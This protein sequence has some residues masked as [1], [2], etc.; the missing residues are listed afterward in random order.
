MQSYTNWFFYISIACAFLTWSEWRGRLS[1]RSPWSTGSRSRELTLVEWSFIP[2][3]LAG[4]SRNAGGN[5]AMISGDMTRMTGPT[6]REWVDMLG[7]WLLRIFPTPSHGVSWPEHRPTVK[8]PSHMYR[9][10][11]LE[12]YF[13]MF[14]TDRATL[15]VKSEFFSSCLHK[16][17]LL[18]K[19][20]LSP[21]WTGILPIRYSSPM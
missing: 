1:P 19:N 10:C 6:G 17:K 5:I 2:D 3:W 16:T 8:S 7:L 14:Q 12:K 21:G 13:I 18:L 11:L 9:L 20:N 4:L 15:N